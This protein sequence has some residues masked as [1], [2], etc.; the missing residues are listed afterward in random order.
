[1]VVQKMNNIYQTKTDTF[2]K[3]KPTSNNKEKGVVKEV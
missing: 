3:M 1:M 2:L